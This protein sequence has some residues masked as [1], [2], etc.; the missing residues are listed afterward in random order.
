MQT[1]RQ[2][3][4]PTE[5]SRDPDDVVTFVEQFVESRP[6]DVDKL[7]RADV[8]ERHLFIWGGEFSTGWVPLRAL[9]LDVPDLP[10]RA[11]RLP[12]EVTHVWVAPEAVP[13]SRIVAWSATSSGVTVGTV[14]PDGWKQRRPLPTTAARVLS[15]WQR[16]PRRRHQRSA[17]SSGP[18]GLRAHPRRSTRS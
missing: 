12:E 7:R 8:D 17:V 2:R 9:Q 6:S 5:L 10:V 15:R 14:T 11:P 4:Q 3:W 1:R 13:P 18:R 16:R